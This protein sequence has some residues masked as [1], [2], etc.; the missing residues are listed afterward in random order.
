MMELTFVVGTSLYM[1][2][3]GAETFVYVFPK[4]VK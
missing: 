4:F 1:Y 2:T 3:S